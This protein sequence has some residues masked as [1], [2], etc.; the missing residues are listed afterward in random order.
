ML[1]DNALAVD[2]DELRERMEGTV[3]APRRPRPGTRRAP[4]GTSPST[5]ARRSSRSRR[6]P[7]TSSRSSTSPASAACAS[8]RRAPATTP[9]AI[10][11]LE[12]TILRQDARACAAS[13]STPP[14]RRAR[15]GAGALW[16]EV[17]GPASRARP[18]AARRL[19]ARRRRRRLHARRRPEL[20]RAHATA[21]PPT[22]CSRSSSSPPT[23]ASCAAT[24]TTSPSCS[25]RCAAA[26]AASASSPRSSS[27][28]TPRRRSTPARC[29][30]RGSGRPRSS[31]P[32]ASGAARR[33][34]RSR[35]RRA[36]SRSRRC[37]T[38]RSRVRGRQF[39]AI[40]GAYL[41]SAEAAAEVLAPLRALEPEI[42][43]FA[44]I[45][46]AALSHIHMDPEHPVP[47]HGD[48][49]MLDELD[50]RGDRGARRRRR[51]GLGLAA[52]DG[53]AAPARRRVRRAAG[54]ARRAREDRAAR[55]RSS[56][57]AWR[58]TPGHGRRGRRRT[59][60]HVIEAMD[61][62]DAGRR[63]LN[64]TERPADA[65][66]FFPE[67]TLRRLQAVKRAYDPARRLPREPPGDR[68]L[69]AAA[70]GRT[71]TKGLAAAGPFGVSGP[72]R[73]SRSRPGP[74]R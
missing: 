11:S 54:R 46:A 73:G 59:S 30:G 43:M 48:G 1:M 16:A 63:Y 24:A 8:P 58:W 42:D 47:G 67:G 60:T 72:I 32:G 2:V 31:R 25:G 57:S 5:S 66:A 71:T 12:R 49:M 37:R 64:F 6:P 44:P 62:W 45:P 15:V 28:S 4:R 52:A 55:S 17:T 56:P 33:P 61:P 50:A 41:G 14:R 21:S 68:R 38:S 23:A 3:V 36:C 19:L 27:S 51:P 7:P 22:A 39:V 13:R 53:R 18:R 70:T 26:A 35:R 74:T 29:S 40:D 9:R 10:A 20:A 34:T 69:T 65:G